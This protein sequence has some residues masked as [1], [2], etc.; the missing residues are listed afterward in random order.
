MNWSTVLWGWQ[1]WIE[2]ISFARENSEL[3]HEGH[4]RFSA[5][6]D[7]AH[8]CGGEWPWYMDLVER[9][10]GEGSPGCAETFDAMRQGAAGLADRHDVVKKF[11]DQSAFSHVGFP[12]HPP[13]NLKVQ[14][15]M[16]G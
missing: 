10:A 13:A 15:C 3:D 5:P 4:G 11:H 12:A 2:N 7:F 16:P 9:W 8:S 14:V 6:T 1:R